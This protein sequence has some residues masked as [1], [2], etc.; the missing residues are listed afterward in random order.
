MKKGDG[1][2]TED[3]M[4]VAQ[5]Y[6]QV[7]PDFAHLSSLCHVRVEVTVYDVEYNQIGCLHR[8]ID[9][10][11]SVK[12]MIGP[13]KTIFGTIFKFA[14]G[15]VAAWRRGHGGYNPTDGG[16]KV[17]EVRS[18]QNEEQDSLGK[19]I[20]RSEDHGCGGGSRTQ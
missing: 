14:T 20:N 17:Q 1:P 12:E 15:R 8:S 11:G 13:M 4:N 3:E 5:N 9:V 6:R 16:R 18:A 10:D 19:R 2:W 7:D